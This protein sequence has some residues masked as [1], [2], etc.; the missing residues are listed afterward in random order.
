ML[1]GISGAPIPK[2]LLYAS[3]IQ[4]ACEKVNFPPCLAYAIAWRESISGEVNGSWNACTVIAPDNGYGLFQLTYPFTDPW[5][6]QNW[7]DPEVNVAL[8]LEH[9]L[10]PAMEFFVGHGVS[11][12]PLVACIAAGFNSGDETAWVNHL[13]GNVDL[14]TT[15]GYASTVLANYHRLIA[16]H[17]PA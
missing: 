12:N 14:G 8:A 15:D 3:Q 4:A 1:N 10:V 16:G 5:P 13:A 11:G 7:E 17:A 9:F 6:P 2:E